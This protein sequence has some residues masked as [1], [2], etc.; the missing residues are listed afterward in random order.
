MSNVPPS[1]TLPPVT[2][3][4]NGAGQ[5]AQSICRTLSTGSDARPHARVNEDDEVLADFAVGKPTA[6][7][8]VK[9][10][11]TLPEGEMT[12][13]ELAEA[14]GRKATTKPAV[15][16]SEEG[17][18]DAGAYLKQHVPQVRKFGA[19]LAGAALRKK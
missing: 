2:S 10:E 18:F 14:L 1:Q 9:A 19:A 16:E 7:K 8:Q 5:A 3:S 13:K 11:A 4:Q 17:E 12:L 6:P 15:N